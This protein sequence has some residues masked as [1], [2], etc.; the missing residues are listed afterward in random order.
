MHSKVFSALIAEIN[1]AYA[2]HGALMFI[3]QSAQ[4]LSGYGNYMFRACLI[5]VEAALHMK[6]MQKY[7]ICECIKSQYSSCQLHV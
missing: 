1:E 5:N 2:A 6:S 4:A 3:S 7:L